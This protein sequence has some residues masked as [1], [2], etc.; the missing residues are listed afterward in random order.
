M[1]GITG[2]SGAPGENE[3]QRRMV[4]FCAE[5]RLGVNNTYFMHKNL[6]I[7]CVSVIRLLRVMLCLKT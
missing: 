3:N 1:E 2:V 5:S 4:D 7:D 6:V